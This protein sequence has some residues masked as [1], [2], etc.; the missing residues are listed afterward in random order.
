[1]CQYSFHC[2]QV[3]SFSFPHSQ[4]SLSAEQKETALAKMPTLLEVLGH[5]FYFGGY[6]VGP[7]VR[8]SRALSQYKD[9]ILPV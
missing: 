8:H 2:M 6:L 7:Q 9:D 3:F 4:E 5:N 1:M